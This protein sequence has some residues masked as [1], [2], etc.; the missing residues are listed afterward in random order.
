[1]KT[2]IKN[3]RGITLIA[4]VVTLVILMIISSVIITE[5]NTG[6]EFK[7]YQYMKADIDIITDSVLIYCKKYTTLPTKGTNIED[8][9]LE[10]QASSDDNDKYYEVDLTKLD[11]MTLNY[12]SGDVADK[13]IYIINEKSHEIYYLKGIEY[14]GGVKHK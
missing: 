6:N 3:N 8:I 5:M 2:N 14:D 9:D 11:N 1:M 12:G 13:D 4:L 10:G 7:K